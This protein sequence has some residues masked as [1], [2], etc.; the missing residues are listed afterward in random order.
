VISYLTG[1]TPTLQQTDIYKYKT[2]VYVCVHIH[3]S[4][5]PLVAIAMT[6][7]EG[8]YYYILVV[9]LNINNCKLVGN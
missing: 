6:A 9:K 7:F 4:V 1:L 8:N 2:E 5:P 3:V